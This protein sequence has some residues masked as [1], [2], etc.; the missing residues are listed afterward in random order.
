MEEHPNAE[1][2]EEMA[3]AL[4][5][6]IN[7]IPK[8]SLKLNVNPD[9]IKSLLENEFIGGKFAEKRIEMGEDIYSLTQKGESDANFIA[10]GRGEYKDEPIELNENEIVLIHKQILLILEN[11]T[12]DTPV[13]LF[14][15]YFE[16]YP[17]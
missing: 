5:H 1:L 10:I 14:E 11:S 7:T 15:R 16:L 6:G 17:K 13:D 12:K 2:I 3:F 8:L 9:I 4:L